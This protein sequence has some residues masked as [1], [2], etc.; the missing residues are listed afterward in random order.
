[1]GNFLD[2]YMKQVEQEGLKNGIEFKETVQNDT[3]DIELNDTAYINNLTNEG[4]MSDS[5]FKLF[6]DKFNIDWNHVKQVS[7]LAEAKELLKQ[8]KKEKETREVADY[9]EKI[10]QLALKLRD[11]AEGLK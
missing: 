11:E 1:M 5:M 2:D 9:K 7:E 3:S 4:M 8:M 6:E 10:K